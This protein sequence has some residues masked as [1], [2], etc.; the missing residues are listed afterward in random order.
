MVY[1]EPGPGIVHGYVHMGGRSGGNDAGFRIK[2]R[3][4]CNSIISNPGRL[5]AG[6][7]GTISKSKTIS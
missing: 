4:T 2:L 7:G 6:K 1:S 5:S 3:I